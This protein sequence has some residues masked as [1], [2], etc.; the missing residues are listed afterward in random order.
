MKSI[1]VKLGIMGRIG[2]LLRG[3]IR[4]NFDSHIESFGKNGDEFDIILRG[5][6]F[7]K[8]GDGVK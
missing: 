1:K 4:L 3:Y 7:A 6:E 2:V 8:S 5:V